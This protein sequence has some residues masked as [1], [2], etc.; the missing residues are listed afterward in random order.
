[1][2]LVTGATSGLGRNA[3]H[4]LAQ[5]GQAVRA[6]GRNLAQGAALE[7]AGIAFVRADLA[8]AS[9][10]EVD[11]LLEGVD[12][13][14]HC[15]ALSSP[16]GRAADFQAANVDATQ[17]LALAAARRGVPRFVHVST[18][19]IYF[20]YQHHRELPETYRARRPVNHYAASKAQ[21]EK[22]ILDIAAQH[23]ATTF[24]MLRPRGLFEIGRAHV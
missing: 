4:S 19:S 18:P 10:V 24:V 8:R 20:D 11:R 23:A 21:A 16:W 6:T 17:R 5:S 15:A 3:V 7:Q 22:V 1:M 12:A 14:W 2:I 9:D 13:V